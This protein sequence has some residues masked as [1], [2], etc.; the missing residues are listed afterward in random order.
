MNRAFPPINGLAKVLLTIPPIFPTKALVVEAGK[1]YTF[2]VEV[3]AEGETVGRSE[4]TFTVPK[5]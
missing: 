3:I 5:T 4:H 1:T 2:A